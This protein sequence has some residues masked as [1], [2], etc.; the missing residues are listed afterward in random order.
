MFVYCVELF[1]DVVS[2]CGFVMV[3]VGNDGKIVN[4]VGGGGVGGVCGYVL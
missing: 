2:E 4:L 1:K 3:D